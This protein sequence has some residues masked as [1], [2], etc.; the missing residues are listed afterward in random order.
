[1]RTDLDIF[2]KTGERAGK[3]VGVAGVPKK[4][5]FEHRLGRL[6]DEQRD[7]VGL[8]GGLPGDLVPQC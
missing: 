8:G 1:V 3:L 5:R 4:A 7:A 6:L 2:A